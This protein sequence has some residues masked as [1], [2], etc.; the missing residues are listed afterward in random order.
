MIYFD[1]AATS[2]PKPPQVV[3]AQQTALT[4]LGGNPGRGGHTMAAAAAGEIFRVRAQAAKLFGLSKPE[5]VIFTANC[6]GA[7]NLLTFGLLRAGDHVV[8][9]DLEHNSV[10][11]PLHE[12]Q[13]RGIIT[14]SIAETS[15]HDPAQTVRAFERCMKSNTRL[16][17]C[18][19]ASNVTGTVLPIEE[20]AGLAHSRGALIGIDAAQS[21]G[22][23]DIHMDNMELD[24]VCVPGHKGL[25]G[26]TGTGMLLIRW[27]GEQLKPF[28]YGGTGSLSAA[29]Y[30]PDFYPDR[31]ECGTLN[32]VGICGLGAGIDFVLQKTAKR[33]YAHE[34][35]LIEMADRLLRGCTGVEIYTPRPQ[36]NRTAGVLSFNVRG[37][38]GEET[39]SYLS[40]RGFALRGGLHCSGL[41]HKKLGTLEIGTARIGVGYNNNPAQVIALVGAIKRFQISV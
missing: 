37:K 29:P 19:H 38:T 20:L 4:K 35:A 17:L 23:L 27:D 18:T 13:E 5:N 6:T 30:Q 14:F 39:T 12:L 40:D 15:L 36:Y 8:T 34:L 32:V 2:Y 26:P 11:R 22:V 16:I 1:N 33:I 24:F 10:L 3:R 7:L 41:A 25:Y 9:S 31:L 21:S 28:M